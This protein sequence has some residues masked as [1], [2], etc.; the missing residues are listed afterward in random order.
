ML[1]RE[2]AWDIMCADYVTAL[3]SDTLRDVA[4]KLRQAMED[5]PGR[6][7]AVVLSEKG[8]FRGVI[9]AWWLLLSLERYARKDS[10]KPAPACDD[11]EFKTAVRKA[12][13]RRVDEA[14]E[15][16]VPVVRPEDS[17]AAVSKAMMVAK[18]RW[19]VVMEGVS[20]LGIISG[21]DIFMQIDWDQR[22]E[23][24]GRG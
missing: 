6:E 5:R 2:R 18:R 22:G 13:S 17:L 4:A 1:L 14:V 8:E 3:E 7:C 15:R 10:L 16:D 24:R 23:E 12:L 21:E 19:A 11:E 9:T 20:V